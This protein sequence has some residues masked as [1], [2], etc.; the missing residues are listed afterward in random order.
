M[1][2]IFNRS[3]DDAQY[4][5]WVTAHPT[6]YVVNAYNPPTAKYLKLHRASCFTITGTP[7][8]GEAWV[9]DY[10]KMCA[11]DL[12]DLASWVKAH[13]GAVPEPCG[14]CNPELPQG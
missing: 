5:R 1:I 12:T 4:R 10:V 2:V 11:E 9:G 14:M 8:T 3:A 13:T 6:G 7:T